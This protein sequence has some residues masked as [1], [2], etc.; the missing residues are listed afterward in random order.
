MRRCNDFGFQDPGFKYG[1]MAFAIAEA[2]RRFKGADVM[3]ARRAG[4][5]SA[6]IGQNHEMQDTGHGLCTVIKVG[7]TPGMVLGLLK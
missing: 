6:P 3:F 7:F 4:I 5:S 2:F 1:R